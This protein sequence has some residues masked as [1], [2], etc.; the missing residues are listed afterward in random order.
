[1]A[2]TAFPAWSKWSP[3]ADP[4]NRTRPGSWSNRWRSSRRSPG[5]GWPTCWPRQL[6]F[7]LNTPVP[8]DALTLEV[9]M[10]R[11]RSPDL[12]RLGVD[13]PLSA[14]RPEPGVIALGESSLGGHRLGFII[15]EFV[16]FVNRKVMVVPVSSGQPEAGGAWRPG[17]E[18]AG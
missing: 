7:A 12:I 15:D 5:P 16:S 14:L 1:M 8:L 11:N 13:V 17:P 9:R 4:G 6:R 2:P 18:P 3:T 10:R